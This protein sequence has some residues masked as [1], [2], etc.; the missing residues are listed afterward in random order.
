MISHCKDRFSNRFYTPFFHDEKLFRGRGGGFCKKAPTSPTP[1]G[2]TKRCKTS[3]S[4]HFFLIHP[5]LMKKRAKPFP[6]GKVFHKAPVGFPQVL[7]LFS[8]DPKTKNP[9]GRRVCGFSTV[10]TAPTTITTKKI[11][12]IH[13]IFCR[14]AERIKGVLK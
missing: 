12:S 10:S 2:K 14:F 13:T 7:H 8:K 6:K 5:N 4:R 3:F 1:C 11:I 9:H